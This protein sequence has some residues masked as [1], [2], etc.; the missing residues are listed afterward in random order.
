V[1][2]RGAQSFKPANREI[3]VKNRKHFEFGPD[4]TLP[5]CVPD[6]PTF[7]PLVN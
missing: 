6:C 3:G 5:L 7:A 4:P 1:S 2:C